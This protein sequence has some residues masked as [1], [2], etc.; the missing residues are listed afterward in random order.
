MWELDH[1][2]WCWRIDAFQLWCWRRLLKVPWTARRSNQLI[3]RE[4][5]PEYSLEGL[6]L[7]VKHQY[8]GHLICT[9]THWKSPWSWERSMA[10]G[11]EGF[12]RWDG[13]MAS[14]M[15]CTWTWVN[16]GRWWGTG[17]PGML[18]SMGSQRVR[19]DWVT[20]QQ[21]ISLFHCPIRLCISPSC[22]CSYYY[23]FNCLVFI[24]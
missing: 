21:N 24:S 6:M 5:N 10:E 23:F 22:S 11:E 1:K 13:W 8:F 20:E 9:T 15:Q 7:K 4:I 12:R 2:V 3:L 14:P 19:H 17:R 16:S 18:Q